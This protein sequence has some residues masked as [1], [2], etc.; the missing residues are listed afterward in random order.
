MGYENST[1]RDGA[2][3][4]PEQPVLRAIE[5]ATRENNARFGDIVNSI[6]NALDR[7][8]GCS[9]QPTAAP[10]GSCSPYGAT[11]HTSAFAEVMIEALAEKERLLNYL[12]TQMGRLNR[13]V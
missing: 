1:L 3:D 6:D 4:A 7:L 12:Q 11:A 5:N 8:L 10:S 9:P 13:A 2:C